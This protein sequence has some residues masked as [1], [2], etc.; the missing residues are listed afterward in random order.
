MLSSFSKPLHGRG[1]IL[2]ATGTVGEHF[3]QRKLRAHHSLFSSFTEVLAAVGGI[4]LTAFAI[5]Q[6]PRQIVMRLSYALG[7]RLAQP[8]PGGFRIDLR[9]FPFAIQQPNLRLGKSQIL[10]GSFQTVFE[11]CLG[12]SIMGGKVLSEI[13]MGLSVAQFGGFAEPLFGFLG[14]G[15]TQR[16]TAKQQSKVIHRRGELSLGCFAIPLF[17]LLG[18]GIQTGT[19]GI[20]ES[21]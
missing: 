4:R 3:G 1:F 15:F 14:I 11:Y 10:L 8:F 7:G 21:E 2:I 16:I 13:I 17:G 19:G 5:A 18:I 6:H 12:R 20:L 9:A